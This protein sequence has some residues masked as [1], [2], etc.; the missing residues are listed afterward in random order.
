MMV[1]HVVT[2][3]KVLAVCIVYSAQVIKIN[4]LYTSSLHSFSGKVR[5]GKLTCIIS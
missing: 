2:V 4:L 1:S 3:Y 5:F